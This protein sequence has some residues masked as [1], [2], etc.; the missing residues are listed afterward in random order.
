MCCSLCTAYNAIFSATPDPPHYTRKTQRLCAFRG[1]ASP[2][3]PYKYT[4]TACV[5]K[6]PLV[7]SYYKC[8]QGEL[9]KDLLL[10][11]PPRA[12]RRQTGGQRKMWATTI[13]A[14]L[15][16]L[17]SHAR[18][19]KD[20]VKVFSELTQYRPEVPLSEAWSTQLVMRAQSAPGE[21]IHMSLG[22]QD[23]DPHLR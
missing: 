16:P 11:I 2:N 4:G 9:I 3:L 23:V 19:R 1:T 22:T 5:K 20:W 21:C 17:L 6:A 7:L 10:P 8:P 18:W 13:K 12:W 14:E 15:Y